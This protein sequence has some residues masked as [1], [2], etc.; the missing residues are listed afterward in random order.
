MLTGVTLDIE[1]QPSH[2]FRHVENGRDNTAPKGT[3]ATEQRPV[4]AVKLSNA[5]KFFKE[6]L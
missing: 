5:S 3:A 1:E 2:T 6:P 4:V